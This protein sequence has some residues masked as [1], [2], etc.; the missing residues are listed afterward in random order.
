MA[1]RRFHQSS[2]FGGMLDM[3]TDRC[4]TA[5][6]LLILASKSSN[7][8]LVATL[9]CLLVLDMSSHWA[10]MVMSLHL[11]QHHK[12]GMDNEILL[13]KNSNISLL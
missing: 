1:A 5:G 11:G 6:L 2:Y 4:S 9:V 8:A 12:S 3:I 13:F 10:Q 7:P